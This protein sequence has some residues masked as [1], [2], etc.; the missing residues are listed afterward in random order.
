M[1]RKVGGF[2]SDLAGEVRQTGKAPFS[3]NIRS[4]KRRMEGK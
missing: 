4:M 3:P 1:R 2:E